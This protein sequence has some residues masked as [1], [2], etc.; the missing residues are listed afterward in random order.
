MNQYYR[1]TNQ[2]NINKINYYNPLCGCFQDMCSCTMGFFFPFCLFGRIYEKAGFG[3][4]WVGCCKFFSLQFFISTFFSLIMFFTEW[5]MLITKIPD[6]DDINICIKNTTCENQYKNFN[7]TKCIIDNTTIICDCLK[8]PL[9]KQC[10]F[11]N[12]L[13]DLMHDMSIIIFFIYT[14]S[15]FTI[16]KALP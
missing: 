5:N 16:C 14:L 11:N 4:W 6:M 10:D 9:Q 7:S 12:K 1:I 15:I 8:E 2:G 13:P 3:S